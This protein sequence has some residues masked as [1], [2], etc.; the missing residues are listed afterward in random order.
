MTNQDNQNAP[1]IAAIAHHRHLKAIVTM[2][3]TATMRSKRLAQ[4]LGNRMLDGRS[5]A[6][7]A[8]SKWRAEIV[9]DLGG[10]DNMSAQK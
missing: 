3:S 6:S 1:A 2:S 10:P 8:L 9:D 4:K 7:V 5:T